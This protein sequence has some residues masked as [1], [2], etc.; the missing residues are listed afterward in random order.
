MATRFA[1]TALFDAVVSQF[2][3]DGTSV[4]NIFG[5]REQAKHLT[6]APRITWQPGDEK[7]DMGPFLPARNPGRNPRPLATLGE[8]CTIDITGYDATAPEDE[9]KQYEATRLLFDAWHRAVYLAAFGTYELQSTT[10]DFS[11]KER[12][13]GATI[14]VV[15]A[16]QAMLPD[17][18]VEIAPTDTHAELDVTELNV[19]D[20]ESIHPT[21]VD[22]I[23]PY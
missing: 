8:L 11:K 19:T 17:A 20:H 4:P 2:A 15:L 18:A 21:D 23:E 16:V 13:H 6:A 22:P 7:G 12:R 14:R 9:R 1:L 10:W 3:T 5:W